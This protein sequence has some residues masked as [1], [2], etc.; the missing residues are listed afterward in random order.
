MFDVLK[1][2][3]ES[4]VVGASCV[5]VAYVAAGWWLCTSVTTSGGGCHG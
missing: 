1:Y 5:W 3:I 2:K 4:V